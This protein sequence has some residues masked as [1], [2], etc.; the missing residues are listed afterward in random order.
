MP[1]Q[2]SH[3]FTS[4]LE[5]STNKLWGCHVRVPGSVAA[6]LIRGM[7]R[8]VLCSM[9]GTPERQCAIV[10]YEKG[11]FVITVNAEQRKTL[12]LDFGASVKVR[13]RKDTSEYGLPMPEE[14]NELLRQDKDGRRL[15]H[16]LTPGRLRTLLYIVGKG[17]SVDQRLHRSTVIVRHLKENSGKINYKQLSIALKK[18]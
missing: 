15:F 16:A 3:S 7:D 4:S 14:L 11:S 6:T 13:L 9:N 12:R 5:K 18:R 17:S 8:R 2:K 1:A 10:A